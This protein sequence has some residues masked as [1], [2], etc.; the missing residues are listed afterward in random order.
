[1]EN[2]ERKLCRWDGCTFGPNGGRGSTE[3][4]R[5]DAWYCTDYCCKQAAKERRPRVK[6]FK[7]A[8]AF[9]RHHRKRPEI[10]E[11]IVLQLLAEIR[12]PG[13]K[14][15][16]VHRTHL[17]VCDSLGAGMVNNDSSF[18]ARMIIKNYPVLRKF[19]RLGG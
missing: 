16:S 2:K 14:K 6:W 10:Y 8:R 4:R 5:A 3:L 7:R 1:M 17:K 18:Y 12:I 9:L 15:I 19:I 11:K 13:V